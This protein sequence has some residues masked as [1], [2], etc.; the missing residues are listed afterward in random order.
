M[1]QLIVNASDSKALQDDLVIA[2][3]IC[4]IDID[5]DLW[6]DFTITNTLEAATIEQGNGVADVGSFLSVFKCSAESFDRDTTPH[7]PNAK[8]FLCLRSLSTDVE[9]A[10]IDKMVCISMICLY[11]YCLRF[12]THTLLFKTLSWRRRS[13][14]LDPKAWVSF[15]M[16]PLYFQV[17][18][19]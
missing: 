7:E 10:S 17:L 14:K 8:L 15:L 5:V 12:R 13:L 2:E 9:I 1:I 6:V 19:L 4:K 3:D 16:E 18:H 11:H